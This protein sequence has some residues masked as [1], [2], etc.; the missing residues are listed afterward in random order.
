[1]IEMLI[2]GVDASTLGVKMGDNFLND[3]DSLAPLKEFIENKSRLMPGKQVSYNNPQ[4]DERA[5]TLTFHIEGST[6]AEYKSR[7][8]AFES[9]LYAGNIEIE[10]PE[11]E[12]KYRLTYL[13]CASFALNTRRTF[14]KISVKFNEPNPSNRS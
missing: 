2:N 11:L 7:K 14:C 8:K 12:E 3:I 13:S 1:M 5:L 9:I 4:V 6:T 10:V